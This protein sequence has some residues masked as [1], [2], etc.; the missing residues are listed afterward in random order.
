MSERE[1]DLTELQPTDNLRTETLCFLENLT[2]DEIIALGLPQVWNTK[3]GLLISDGNNRAAV[4]S[5]RNYKKI[6]V[7]YNE[8][9]EEPIFALDLIIKR[10]KNMTYQGISSV[11]D[12]WNI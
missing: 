9:T 5:K 6:K 8:Q 2:D 10:A 7:D 12:L 4:L 3:L 1:I 11:Y